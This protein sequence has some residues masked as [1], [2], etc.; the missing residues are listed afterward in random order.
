[1]YELRNNKSGWRPWFD[2][3]LPTLLAWHQ[4]DPVD[5]AERDRTVAIAG[6]QGN[7]NPFVL[8]PTLVSRVFGSGTVPDPDGDDSEEPGDGGD[9]QPRG[10]A[11]MRLALLP[12]PPGDDAGQERVVLGN[13]GLAAAILDGWLLRDAAG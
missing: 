3:Q 2:S 10:G 12:N 11:V 9:Q 5:Q 6:V 7:P 13:S 4:Q 8:D 1:I